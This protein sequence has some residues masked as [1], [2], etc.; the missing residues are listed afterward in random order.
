MVESYLVLYGP[1][2]S[3]AEKRPL[4]EGKFWPLFITEDLIAMIYVERLERLSTWFSYNDVLE[5][6]STS[7]SKF[8]DWIWNNW[9]FQNISAIFW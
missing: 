4:E 5:S 3:L 7:D 6:T 1:L 2:G 8:R 9:L